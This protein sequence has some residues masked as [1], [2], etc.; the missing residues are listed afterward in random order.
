MAVSTADQKS[1]L[2]LPQE[3][4]VK[5]YP[6]VYEV[7]KRSAS[8]WK[9][10][11]PDPKKQAKVINSSKIMFLSIRSRW[12]A[13]G[14]I[15]NVAIQY[16]PGA[17]TIFVNDYLD[18]EGNVQPGLKK[19]YP[20]GELEGEQYRRGVQSGIC[21]VDGYLFLENFGGKDNRLLL[22]FV[23]HHALNEK[24]PNYKPQRD[25]NSIFLFKPFLPEAK[26]E[27]NLER[28]DIEVE[29][30]N[31]LASV[32]NKG[33]Y[34]EAKLNALMAIFDLGGSFG[35]GDNAQK[36]QTL[37]LLER[38]SPVRFMEE[39]N[40]ADKEIRMT[41]AT[42]KTLGVLAITGKDVKMNI[43]K[44]PSK[45]ILTLKSDKEEDAVEA[46]TYYFLGAP[47]GKQDY[48]IVCGE[49]ENKKLE[50]LNKE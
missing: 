3:T 4:L 16:V 25:I 8:Q 34:N 21:F 49:N 2:L 42:A 23:Y 44:A 30:K 15:G 33:D 37:A 17:P 31:L 28:F 6:T 38:H 45:S 13:G 5:D 29:A 47:S 26:A 50:A 1:K 27:I 9:Q 22:D 12:T 48:S 20:G 19:L 46:L 43:G 40:N 18:I 10:R 14:R 39:Y 41:I 24:S 7:S 11:N 32:R 36:M 35:S